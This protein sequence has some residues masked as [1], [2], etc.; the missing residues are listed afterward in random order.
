MI[1][2]ITLIVIT[3]VF[4]VLLSACDQFES[5]QPTP[6]VYQ[7]D[8]ESSSDLIIAE[9]EIVP[10][11][12]FQILSPT[13]GKI[14]EI[15]AQESQSME[16][17]QVLLRFEVPQKL[18]AELK[19]AELDLLKSNQALDDL[20]LYG[21]LQKQKAYQRLLDAQTARRVALAAWDAFDVDQYDD[22]L[23]TIKEDVIDA[24]QELEDAKDELKN[25]LNLEEDNP[26]RKNR[27]DDVDEAQITL[28]EVE[29]EQ[30]ELEQTYEQL[31][32]NLEISRADEETATREYQKYKGNNPPED[33][34]K[35]AEEQ[36]TTAQARLDAIQA[37]ID[38]LEIKAPFKGNVINL[39]V[40][41]GEWISMGQPVAT[42]ADM[43][44][45]FVE[46]TDITELEIVN[47][48]IGD[49]A[50]I[51]LDAF[52]GETIRGKVV[53]IKNFPELKFNDVLYR[54]RIE[55]PEHN[56][57]LRWKMSVIIKIEK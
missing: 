44:A 14:V 20:H 32:L 16:I 50:L 22:D 17:D 52:P 26:Q 19:S 6:V 45:W 51:E 23:E 3:L 1:K 36:T 7:S 18:L 21:D 12:D 33:Q 5:A 43:S 30:A 39:N 46:S 11:Q 47:I 25:F 37:Q 40:Q 8:S 49:T 29:R 34:L 13:N 42:L 53:E 57:P 24:R 31:K 38:D 27:Q 48:D 41:S 56:L 55:L 2:K 28:N 15:L 35:I 4:L 54:V 10:E 9:G